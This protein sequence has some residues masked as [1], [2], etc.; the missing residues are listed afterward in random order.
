ML[1]GGAENPFNSK[2]FKQVESREQRES[3]LLDPTP[4]IVLA[5][6]GMMTGGPIVE[7]FKHWAPEPGN[8]LCFVGYQASGTLGR[9][10]Q[11]GH[12]QVPL[13][14]KGQ[15]LMVDIRCNMV[16]ID[17][18][19]GHSDRNQ[20]MDYVKALNPTPRK[21]ICHHGDP[22]TCN[23]FRKGLREIFKVQTY[24]PDNLETLRLV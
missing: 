14:D 9:R 2:W 24:A 23:A 1:R 8:T 13:V 22:Q 21:I 16:I 20:L 10:L 5:T 11:D 18:F 4:C 7:Y 12:S 3:I 6:S 15:T 19:S 17:G